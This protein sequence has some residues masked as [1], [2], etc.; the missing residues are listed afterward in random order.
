[1]TARRR[2]RP[3]AVLDPMGIDPVSAA[4]PEA[5]DTCEASA[6]T[7]ECAARRAREVKKLEPSSE[8]RMTRSL[9]SEMLRG[10]RAA[11]VEMTLM[12][13]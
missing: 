8:V 10:N 11:R 13:E 12:R 5:D 3:A 2:V 9:D 7:V 1:M 6:K 4:A